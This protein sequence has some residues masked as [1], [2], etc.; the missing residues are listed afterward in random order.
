ML[1]FFT[2]NIRA[3]EFGGNPPSVK[4]RQLNSPFT[5]VIF[6]EGLDSFAR[7]IDALIQQ[8]VSPSRSSIGSEMCKINIVLQNQPT[9]SNGYVALG[10]FRSEFFLTPRQ[11]SFELGSLPWH[12]TLALHEYRHVQQFNNFRKGISKASYYIFGEEGQALANSIAI[13]DWF[14]EGDAV[15]QETIF[16]EQGRGRLPY[17][18]NGYR[19]LW[20]SGKNYSWM[21]LRNGSYRDYVPDHYQLG[22]LLVNYGYHKFGQESWKNITSDAA[23]FKGIFYPFQKAFKRQ[24]DQ[25]FKSFRKEALAYYSSAN[26]KKDFDSTVLL[27]QRKDREVIDQLYPQW[28]GTNDYVFLES[29]FSKIPAFYIQNIKTGIREKI[30][31]KAVSASNYFSCNAQKIVYTSYVPDAR[32]GWRNYEAITIVDIATGK[33]KRITNRKRYLSPAID[34]TGKKIVAVHAD[35]MGKNAMHILD[36]ESGTLLHEVP[37]QENYVFTYPVFD[38]NDSI[39]TAVR[40][41]SGR[42]ALGKFSIQE[43]AVT[44][45]TPFSLEVIAFPRTDS[46]KIYF[47]QSDGEIDKNYAVINDSIFEF[48]PPAA[49]SATGSYMLSGSGSSYAWSTFTSSGFRVATSTLPYLKTRES[50]QPRFPML[51]PETQVNLVPLKSMDQDSSRVYPSSFKLFNFHSWRPYFSDPEYSYSVVSNNILNT[52]QSELYFTYNRNERFKET[53]ALLSYAALYPVLNGGASFTFDRSFTDTARTTTW[54]EFNARAGVNIPLQFT[55]GA[56]SQSLNVGT[57]FNNKQV[58][59]T[60]SSKDLFETKKFNY[61]EFSFA[62][63]NQQLK[64]RQY[65]YPRIAQTIAARYRQ[66]INRYSAHQLLL[67]GSIYLPGI[68]RNHNVVLQAAYQHRDTL[69]QYIFPNSFPISRGYPDIDY[70]RMWKAG[71]NYHLPL[72]Y[73]D[74]GFANIVY[75]LRVRSNV[76]YDFSRVK[77]LRTGRTFQLDAVGTEL[78]F[79]TRWWNQLPVSFGIRYSRLLDAASVGLSPDQWELVLPVNIFTR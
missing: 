9:Y 29:S 21:K 23:A 32:W 48:Q 36:A 3:Q 26:A 18:F 64:A 5:R 60:G 71:I 10:P 54:N 72:F 77:S 63:T 1:L 13:P 44:W 24:T 25:S 19:S 65:I 14:W 59:Y 11:N 66:I 52:L 53:G 79:D 8:L 51:K 15:Y 70:P 74:F 46:G 41:S 33:E 55:S 47:S 76:Y 67:S 49:N 31:D 35:L 61:G 34:A 43:G 39:I 38:G 73:P 12:K 20:A 50:S 40:D 28:I 78:F 7:D 56:F 75:L 68:L 22:Y 16:S 69:Q 57:S 42:M 45:I 6:P 4:W 58:Y 30:R 37:V 62:A 2:G 27:R 17:F